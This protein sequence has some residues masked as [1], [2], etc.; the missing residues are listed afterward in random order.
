MSAGDVR[1]A[2]RG[3]A[4]LDRPERLQSTT[5]AGTDTLP[6]TVTELCAD[7]AGVCES[8]VDPLEIAS[9]LELEGLGD[10]AAKLRYGY[11]DV[12]ALAQDMYFRVPRKP[13]EPELPPDPWQEGGRLRPVLHSL[14][15]ALP[16]V[17]FP[18]AIGLLT[19]SPHR[20]SP[21]GATDPCLS[22][23]TSGAVCALKVKTA[24]RSKSVFIERPP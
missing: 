23:F 6:R 17:C 9:A 22:S 19:G 12:F 1:P 8:A 7:F 5:A 20:P 24:D 11:A 4:P 13:V 21:R 3:L 10:Q 15:Y 16:G 2:L 18:A 14:L